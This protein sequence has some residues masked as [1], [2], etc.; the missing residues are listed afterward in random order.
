MAY[1]GN[2]VARIVVLFLATLCTLF[3]IFMPWWT[4]ATDVSG[5]HDAASAQPFHA[6]RLADRQ[7]GNGGTQKGLS[8]QVIVTGILITL[9][10]LAVLG[11]TLLDVLPMMG[12]SARPLANLV[13]ALVS[14]GLGLSAVLYTMFAWPNAMGS[15]TKF[16]QTRTFNGGFFGGSGQIQSYGDIGWFLAIAGTIVLPLAAFV[17]GLLPA[18]RPRTP[19]D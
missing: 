6:G 12:R 7:D 11:F 5:N 16:F 2:Q 4:V 17:L 15:D 8:D 19:L 18:S 10:A 1:S 3:S 13:A 9:A 14:A